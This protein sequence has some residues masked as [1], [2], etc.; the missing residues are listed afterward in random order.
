M[1][2]SIARGTWWILATLASKSCPLKSFEILNFFENR[3]RLDD[4]PS[5]HLLLKIRG[6]PLR[7][8]RY[9]CELIYPTKDYESCKIT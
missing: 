2:C 9:Y 5:R 7:T 1:P 6:S 4:P 8:E 3:D